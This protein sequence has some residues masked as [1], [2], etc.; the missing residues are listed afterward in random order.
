MLARVVSTLV[1]TYS[2]KGTPEAVALAAL[3]PEL[4]RL[5]PDMVAHLGGTRA[6][7]RA[8]LEWCA[9]EMVPAVGMPADWKRH[10]AVCGEMRDR[11]VAGW[12]T[13]ALGLWDPHEGGRAGVIRE[14][15]VLGRRVVLVVLGTDGSIVDRL[16]TGP[17]DHQ[18]GAADV[19]R[20]LERERVPRPR[21]RRAP[22]VAA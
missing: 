8:V 14:A 11:N 10:G 6:G 17:G 18:V 19:L 9:R 2:P 13:V 16:D 15:L 12:C 5:R 20:V 7:D 21:R 22:K 4:D 1:A 3:G